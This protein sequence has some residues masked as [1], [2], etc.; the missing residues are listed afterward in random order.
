MQNVITIYFITK[1]SK[2]RGRLTAMRE[3][4]YNIV[5]WIIFFHGDIILALKV[6]NT[7]LLYLQYILID[8]MSI[9]RN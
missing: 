6:S 3:S 8:T 5:D 2:H 9:N 4:N 1:L 7:A